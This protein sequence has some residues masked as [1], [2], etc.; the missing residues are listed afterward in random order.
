MIDRIFWLI[1]IV[2]GIVSLVK[3]D[4]ENARGLLMLAIIFS[5]SAD[6]NDIKEEV[7][8]LKKGK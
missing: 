3:G 4:T 7:K 6:I 1:S 8:R 2:F 5:N